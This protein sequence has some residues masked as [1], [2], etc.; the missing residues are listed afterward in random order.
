LC[1][2]RA[3]Y[4]ATI[5]VARFSVWLAR[6]QAARPDGTAIETALTM[7]GTGTCAFTAVVTG[8]FVHEAPT[9]P[10]QVLGAAPI[11]EE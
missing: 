1:T 7:T 5:D 11:I 2:I 6:M 8:A 10:R 4:A 3:A 9:V